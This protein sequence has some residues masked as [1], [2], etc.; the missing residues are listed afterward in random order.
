MRIRERCS[1]GARFDVG[2]TKSAARLVREW[3]KA[4]S[5]P[6]RPEEIETRD[7][8]MSAQ[9]ENAIGFRVEGLNVPA[10]EYDPWEDK[11]VS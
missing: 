5:C 8:S 9:V 6:D 2:M 3:R 10:R 4:H 11:S 7:V 1:C